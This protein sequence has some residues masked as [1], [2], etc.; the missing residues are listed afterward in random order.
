[1][2]LTHHHRAPRPHHPARP[3]TILPHH[4]A[5]PV[6]ILPRL[7]RPPLV[8]IIKKPLDWVKSVL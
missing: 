7:L 1:M 8:D 5:R 2:V 4:P 3:V 6:T